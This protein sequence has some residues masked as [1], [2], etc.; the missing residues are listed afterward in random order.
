MTHK[1]IVCIVFLQT[2]FSFAVPLFVLISGSLLLNPAK[3]ISWQM[4]LQKYIF[5]IIRVLLLF[6]FFMCLAE[7]Y[8]GQKADDGV[9]KV[10]VI[11]IVNLITG[12]CWTHMWYL[13]TLIG[14][15]ALTPLFKFYI[16]NASRSY[17]HYLIAVLTVMCVILP[18]LQK[19][20]PL[21][22]NSWMLLSQFLFIYPCGY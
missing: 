18:F 12:N 5:R 21:N 8:M 16:N 13:Y 2:F 9:I 15:Y 4:I 22:V 19:I 14:L 20:E 3:E 17:F 10:I 7:V 6:G 11:S 1:N